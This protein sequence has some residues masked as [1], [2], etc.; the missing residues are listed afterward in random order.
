MSSKVETRLNDT[1]LSL[2][3]GKLARQANGSV[4]AQFGDTVVLCT[5]VMNDEPRPGVDFFPLTCDLEERFYSAGKIPGSFPR[6]EG[7]PSERAVL[8]SRLIDRP[9][10]P[11]FP[12]GFRNDVQVICTVMS[13]DG[14]NWPD[15]VALVGASAALH[16][17]D[18]PFLGPIAA[19]RVGRIEGELVVNPT[20]EQ[21]ETSDLDLVVAGTRD[22]V[23]MI[24]AAA[25]EVAEADMI[26]AIAWA[27]EQLIP[28]CALQEEL[29][30]QAGK[31]KVT[32]PVV[33][34][35]EDAVEAVK[36]YA[37]EIRSTI[38]DPDKAARE[39]AISEMTKDIVARVIA[40]DE[41]FAERTSDLKQAV[42]KV[43][44]Q[45][46]RSLIL[47]EGKRPDGRGLRDLRD[48]SA[49]IGVLPR[50]HGSGLFTRGQTQV[51]STATLGSLGDE[52]LLDSLMG[53][54]TKRYL[55]H[56]NFPPYSVG[57]ARPLRGTG[58]REIGHGALAEKAI[59]PMLPAFEDFP[60][61][62]RVVSDV[63]E[64]NGS[65]SMASTCGSSLS[66]MAAGVPLKAHVGGIAMGLISDGEKYVVLTDIQGME[67]FSGDMDFKVTGTRA[68]ITAIQM[69]T[70]IGGI[71]EPVFRDAIDQARDARMKVLDV[72]E[73]AIPGPK[74]ELSEYAPR[75]FKL[76]INP[77]L[78][79]PL[80]GPGGKTIKKIQADTGA[81][82]DIEQDGTV[83]IAAVDGPAGDMARKMVEALTKEVVVGEVFT[84][85]V[86]RIMGIGAFVE[87]VPGKDGLLPPTEIAPI[88]PNR[89]EDVVNLGDVIEVRVKEV[90]SQ[91]RINLTRRD[92]AGWE[93]AGEKVKAA[94]PGRGGDRG[95]RGDRGPR[96]GQGRGDRSDRGPRGRGENNADNPGVVGFRFRPKKG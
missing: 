58:R 47:E 80:I 87:I 62:I 65:S 64:S 37:A 60:Y 25:N 63:L 38:Q 46:V 18:I 73:A 77:E 22:D 36:A 54:N 88:R 49:E 29:R 39:N 84:G 61:V 66:L 55:H 11:L 12:K 86:T 42:D 10:R 2:E 93:E 6:R 91:G 27:H 69:D 43:V 24:E 89:I 96:G 20:L 34:V 30:E 3:T 26:A 79:G 83:Y 35:P 40:A 16:I 81:K 45:Q 31:P 23:I 92:L 57:E 56:Y 85:T 90:D 21:M 19:V 74:T 71:P 95:D 52:Q 94:G 8:T 1:V 75:V 28:L 76:S 17:S 13:V 44:K 7:R 70:K 32:P 59:R 53:D 4:V 68:G 15:V 48:L 78:I 9:I 41:S 14:Q 5:A 67:D 33:E 50:A 51:L 82:I 72:M